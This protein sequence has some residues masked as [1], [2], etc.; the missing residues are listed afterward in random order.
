MTQKN[1]NCKRC[2]NCCLYASFN[3]VEEADIRLWEKNDR[4][5]I[6]EWVRRKPIGDGEY[7]YEVWI[8]PRTRHEVDRCPWLRKLP[9]NGQYVCK[10]H[11]LKPT[12]CR[13][14]PASRKHAAEI[15]CKGFDE[16]EHRG[17]GIDS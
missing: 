7:A 12:I 5:D 14:F 13:Y 17:P 2:G 4:I 6:L 1:F 3:E 8:D 9:H 11:N 15:G 16:G 10:I